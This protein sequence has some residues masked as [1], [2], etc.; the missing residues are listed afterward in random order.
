[1]QNDVTVTWRNDEA[2]RGNSHK[3]FPA[4]VTLQMTTEYQ[5]AGDFETLM[6]LL[7]DG[8]NYRTS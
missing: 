1:M 5:Y 7:A 8:Q 2:S 6:K 3:S 4:F